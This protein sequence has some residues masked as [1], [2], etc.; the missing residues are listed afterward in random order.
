MRFLKKNILMFFKN[1]INKIII[2]CRVGCGRSGTISDQKRR[3]GVRRWHP[4]EN[5]VVESVRTRHA[6]SL[7]GLHGA[8]Y[9]RHAHIARNEATQN[10]LQSPQLSP[11]VSTK[12]NH[13]QNGLLRSLLAARIQRLA[14][15]HRSTIRRD[16]QFQF[17]LE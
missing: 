14:M 9:H 13:R 11:I 17:K 8:R 12:A 10:E 3:R 2:R 7:F 4:G 16:K 6:R 15:F 5:Q 1:K